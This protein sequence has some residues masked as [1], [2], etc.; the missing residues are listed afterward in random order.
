D[1][2]NDG[3]EDGLVTADGGGVLQRAGAVVNFKNTIIAGNF[4]GGA[5]SHPDCSGTLNS[6]GHNLVSNTAG[7][8]FD[9]GTGDLTGFPPELGPLTNYGG[10]TETHA[11]LPLSPAIDA[12]NPGMPGTGGETCLADDQRRVARPLDG[13]G[14]STAECDIGAYEADEADPVID[15]DLDGVSDAEDNCPTTPNPDQSDSDNDGVGNACETPVDLRAIKLS[16]FLIRRGARLTYAIGVVNLGPTAVTGVTATDALPPGTTFVRART[17][18]G[19]CTQAASIV[20]CDVG[21]LPRNR[22]ASILIDVTVTAARGT[23]LQNT[24][25]V[26]SDIPDPRPGNNSA[27]ARTRVW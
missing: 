19:S 14:N 12:G 25:V 20:T 1:E 7:C 9:S 18:L 23:V 2:D 27:T 6:Q 8:S 17:N 13:N 21:T 16:S 11:L 10:P 26:S 15:T 4:D 22:T 3:T 24:V 5:T